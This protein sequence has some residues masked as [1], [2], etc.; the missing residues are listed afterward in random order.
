[1][2]RSIVDR[3]KRLRIKDRFDLQ[4]TSMMDMLVIIVVFLL[5]SYSATSVAFATSAKITLPISTAE[6]I[7]SDALNLVIEPV[8]ILFDDKR[9][10]EFKTEPAAPG[11][12]ATE[13]KA[14]TAAYE[15][16]PKHLADGGRRILPLYDAMVKARENAE[17]LMS[18]AVWV[19]AKKAGEA[20]PPGQQAKE[21][22]KPK[23]QGVLTIQADKAVRYDLI[24]KVM[25]TAG[26]AGYKVFKL[27]T[28]KKEI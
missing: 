14:E 18:K 24:R 20:A 27:I 12:P 3:R 4:L 26:A 19:A 25:Y 5:K 11:A 10:L 9:V 13:P 21:I 2:R 23:F 1:M 8:G 7:P 16:D 17:L 22:V 6:E 28:I 15:V